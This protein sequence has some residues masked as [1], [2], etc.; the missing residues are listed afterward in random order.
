MAKAPEMP[1]SSPAQPSARVG[2]RAVLASVALVLV[3][4][5]FALTLA[6]V[7]NRWAPLLSADQ[8]ARDSLHR[9]ALT[10]SGF[11]TTM[12]LISDSGSALAWTVVLAV[13]V[14][15]MLRRGLPRLALFVTITALGSSL[16]NAGVKTVVHRPRP[17]LINPV[18]HELGLSFP[19]GHAQ[20]AMVGYALLLFVFLPVLHGWW[21]RTAVT[22]AV[23]MVLAIGFSRIALG[24]H[25]LSDV[26]GGVVLGAAWVAAMAA[27]FNATRVDHGRRPELNVGPASA[28]AGIAPGRSG[29]CGG[30]SRQRTGAAWMPIGCCRCARVRKRLVAAKPADRE[31][32][33][34]P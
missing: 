26:V 4:L 12:Q 6:L 15:A 16:L 5:P 29:E 19:S 27:A 24:V 11:V 8:S 2:P 14:V 3:A 23:F 25:Y 34:S 21:R 1:A 31:G 9:Y 18:A 32:R 7:K 28:T 22:F 33:R 10:H 20:A 17:E 13:V 30:E